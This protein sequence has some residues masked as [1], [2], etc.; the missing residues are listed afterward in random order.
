MT[1]ETDKITFD[2]S[3]EAILRHFPLDQPRDGQIE[4][5]RFILETFNSGKKFAIL[6]AP[7]GAGKSAIG[8]TV[9]RYVSRSFYLTIQK[10]LQDQLTKEFGAQGSN[11]LV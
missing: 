4:A 3:D 11:L 1:T 2:T 9:S 8:M 10:I 6:E 7:T 5:I